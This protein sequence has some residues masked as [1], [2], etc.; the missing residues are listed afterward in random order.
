MTLHGSRQRFRPFICYDFVYSASGFFLDIPLLFH[1]P[2]KLLHASLFYAI[3]ITLI[4]PSVRGNPHCDTIVCY[5]SKVLS[6]S[7]TSQ[8]FSSTGYQGY[9]VKKKKKLPSLCE[10][11]QNDRVVPR[12][13]DP[14][15]Q[16][17]ASDNRLFYAL[18]KSYFV[19][20]PAV[21]FLVQST[22]LQL[23]P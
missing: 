11:G 9:K 14:A 21:F 4:F 5:I 13:A 15:Y 8:L 20:F 17:T 18:R 3:V 22:L 7:Y 10:G 12:L 19:E 16:L 23:S 1:V 2:N 6:N